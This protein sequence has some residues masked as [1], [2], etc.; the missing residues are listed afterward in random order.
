MRK[1][2]KTQRTNVFEKLP[3]CKR[4]QFPEY[5]IAKIKQV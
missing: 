1:V 3:T 5:D 2:K 4:L